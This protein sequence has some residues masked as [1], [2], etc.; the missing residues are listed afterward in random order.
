MNPCICLIWRA[1]QKDKKVM[2]GAGLKNLILRSLGFLDLFKKN[3]NV[4]T[5]FYKSQRKSFRVSLNRIV[6][7][8]FCFCLLL[9]ESLGQRFLKTSG[10]SELYS[11]LY[12][13]LLKTK[14]VHSILGCPTATRTRIGNGTALVAKNSAQ[15][16]NALSSCS[17]TF[18]LCLLLQNL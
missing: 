15:A 2:R 16:A 18:C 13:C 4:L 1:P 3:R 8:T 5:L 9:S 14:N 7:F 17:F 12:G 11:F 6:S 10:P